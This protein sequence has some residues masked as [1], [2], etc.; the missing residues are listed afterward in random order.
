MFT[1][2]SRNSSPTRRAA[3]LLALPLAA[4]TLFLAGAVSGGPGAEPL[5]LASHTDAQRVSRVEQ[6]FLELAKRGQTALAQVQVEPDRG[7]KH[8][9]HG[10]SY[11][12]GT[13]FPTSGPHDPQPTAPGFY[14]QPQPPTELVHALEHGIVVVYYGDPGFRALS[15]L[16]AWTQL[17]SGHWDGLAVVPHQGLGERV[18][19]TAWRHRLELSSFDDAAAAAFIDAFRGRGPE[20]PVR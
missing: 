9:T 20:H 17:Y 4:A 7:N 6:A 16:R 18:V 2:S 5:Q 12:Y 14:Q 1:P 11:D 19:L 15:T 8:I 13:P 10:A 3:R